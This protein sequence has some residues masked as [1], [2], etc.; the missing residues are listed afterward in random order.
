MEG[1]VKQLVEQSREG[2]VEEVE[3]VG[4]ALGILEELLAKAKRAEA[5]AQGQ[6]ANQLEH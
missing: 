6:T 5:Q 2:G 3:A 4:K 1:A